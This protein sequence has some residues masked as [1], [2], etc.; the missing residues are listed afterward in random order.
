[1]AGVM[2]SDSEY[3]HE[4]QA[5][6]EPFEG[7]LLG[8]F[9]ISVG[10]SANLGLALHVP[11][12]VAIAV[13][14]MMGVK[15]VIGLGLGY[16]KR[17]SLKSAVRFALALP[18]GSEFSFVL[19]G[20]AVA[21]G[22][23]ARTQAD[24][25]TLVI[26]VSMVLTP[27]LFAISERWLIPQFDRRRTPAYD[28][29]D[30]A[31]APVII[32]GFGRMGQVVGRIL[33]MQGIAFTAL[34]KDAAHVEVVRR[35]GSKVFFGN[36]ARA[37]VL[38]AAGADTAKVLVIALDDMDAGLAVAEMAR[39]QFRHLTILARAR[40]RRHAHLLM[41]AGITR[42]VRE[43]FFSSLQLTE[44]VLGALDVAP[45]TASRA[46]ELFRRH[47]EQNLEE[48]QAIAGDEYKLIQSSQQAAQELQDLF[49]ADQGNG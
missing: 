23:L 18:E 40:N 26:A 44:M 21:A 24:L 9:F 5:D 43:T 15:I 7:L 28:R 36:P 46:I 19:F 8:F 16:W 41:G 2:L 17:S 4:V 30:A 48:T 22:A 25:A 42:I 32:C 13:G 14:A 38:R 3:R 39:R 12:R 35:F 27:I 49:E 20:A 31:P 37:D 47:D 45:E 1:M 6:I 29:I 33:R 34:D 11:G 10:M